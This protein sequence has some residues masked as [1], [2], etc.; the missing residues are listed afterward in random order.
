MAEVKKANARARGL[1]LKAYRLAEAGNI[2]RY[3]KN[4]GSARHMFLL[5]ELI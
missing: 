4:R 5:Q 1:E 2:K 3:E